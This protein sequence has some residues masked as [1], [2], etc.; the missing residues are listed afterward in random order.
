M[1]VDDLIEDALGC[2]AAAGGA[3]HGQLGRRRVLGRHNEREDR[4]QQRPRGGDGDDEP[5]P[6]Q[7]RL[8][9][10]KEGG[11]SRRILE[12]SMPAIVGEVLG[13]AGFGEAQD[14]FRAQYAHG[15]RSP[16]GKAAPVLCRASAGNGP[17]VAARQK[18]RANQTTGWRRMK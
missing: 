11:S 10:V 14:A 6:A 12:R 8:N 18:T 5:A 4:S 13:P 9:E 2:L 7:K 16:V 15:S 1:S 3:L 17:A